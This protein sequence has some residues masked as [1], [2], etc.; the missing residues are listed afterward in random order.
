MLA[1]PDALRK[2]LAVLDSRNSY[3]I[4]KVKVVPPKIKSAYFSVSRTKGRFRS[5]DPTY[6]ILLSVP[7]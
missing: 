1:C 2:S 6:I 4:K 5:T 7:S 3:N